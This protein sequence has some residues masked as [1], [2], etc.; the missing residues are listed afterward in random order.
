VRLGETLLS[1]PSVRMIHA[2]VE[3]LARGPDLLRSRPD[4]RYSL[5]DCVSFALMRD[6]G[7]SVA[8]AF[9][10]HLDQEGFAREPRE[11]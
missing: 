7:I 3:A 4:K 10:R 2:G 1:S 11:R 5:T 9:D 6:R 8:L